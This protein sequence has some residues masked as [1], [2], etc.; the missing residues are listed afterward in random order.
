MKSKK[1]HYPKSI[2]HR[3]MKSL[4]LLN[5][6][7]FFLVSCSNEII[8]NS[9]LVERQGKAYKINSEKPFTGD[10]VT[11]HKNGQVSLTTSYKNGLMEGIKNEFYDNGQLLSSVNYFMGLKE[12]IENVYYFSGELHF[13]KMYK[14]GNLT[15]ER[16]FDKEGAEVF[17]MFV[18]DSYAFTSKSDLT[19]ITKIIEDYETGIQTE[20]WSY[21]R[22]VGNKPV[23]GKIVS[24]KENESIDFEG[25]LINGQEN[26][27]FKYYDNGKLIG[28]ENYSDGLLN[29]I[30]RWYE[31]NSEE[32]E[33]SCWQNNL[34]FT[35]MSFCLTE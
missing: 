20:D 10:A 27:I 1:P 25:F 19:K 7:I 9:E 32:Y 14:N 30:T 34:K 16:R 8:E 22:V 29:G 4:L 26:G 3:R 12:G 24:F 15:D 11:Y 2:R 33:E 35:D 6:S 23:T 5:I 18:D 17:Y 28:Y 13:E 21:V 31:Y